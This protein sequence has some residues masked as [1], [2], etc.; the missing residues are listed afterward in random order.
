MTFYNC[1]GEPIA[2]NEDNETVYLFTGEP[3]A[4]FYENAVYGFNGKHLGWFEDG[5]IR[6]IH[7]QCAFFTENASG[8]GPAKPAK[9]SK[10]AKCARYAR[11]A[12]CAR[13]AK[14]AKAARSCSWSNLSGKQFYYQ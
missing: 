9:Y 3:I 6:D 11:P 12:K 7:G 13:H 8:S 5:W 4:Y 10:P 2:Y 1:H 14:Y